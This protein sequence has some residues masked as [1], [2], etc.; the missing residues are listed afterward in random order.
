MVA[1][2]IHRFDNDLYS[3]VAYCIMSNHV[4][5][6]IDTSLQLPAD[7]DPKKWES[8]E[9]K[10]LDEIMKRIKGPSAVYANRF[11]KRKGKFWQKESFDHYVRNEK[12]FWRIINYILNN[13]VK[14]GL[15]ENWEDYPFT[16]LK[17][18]KI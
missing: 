1:D 14:V 9:Y 18:D 15:V 3:L 17:M 10:P 4:H 2:E 13:P 12:E 8:L 11:L 6:L 5:L 16:Y 7:F